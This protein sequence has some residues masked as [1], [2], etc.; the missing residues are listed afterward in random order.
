MKS[1][2]TREWRHSASI[3]VAVALMLGANAMI[4]APGANAQTQAPNSATG[5]KALQLGTI[6][7]T[8]EKRVQPVQEVPM[9]VSVISGAQLERLQAV[10]FSDY[11]ER[12]TGFNYISSGEGQT[13]LILR[14][15]TSG[16]DQANATVGTY[17]D[18]APFGSSTVYAEGSL[19]TPDIDPADIERIE[20]LRGPQGTL[21][22]ANTL[23]GLIKFVTIP[24]NTLQLYGR[25]RIDGTSVQG[26]GS[27]Y[28]FHAM[29]NVPLVSNTLGLRINAYRRIDPGYYNNVA[30]GQNN[31]NKDTVNG[32]R[33]QLLWT[34]NE[35]LSLRLSA[36][37]QNNYNPAGVNGGEDVDPNTLQPIYG[38]LKQNHPPGTGLFEPQYRLYNATV[39]A[40][41]GWAELISS[42]SYDSL[43][44]Q[45]NT[46]VT[47]VYGPL[48]NPL[49]G[50][51]NGGYSVNQPV[52]Q[53]KFTQEIRL[54]SPS[55]DTLEWRAGLFYTHENSNNHQS[56]LTFDATTGQPIALPFTLADAYLGP[57]YFDEYAA[58]G[59]ITYHF[60]PRF[61]LLLG[62]R[63]SHDRTEYTQ[64]TSGV[65]TGTTNFTTS[66]TD[67]PTT[68]LLSPKYK[69][70]KDMMVYARIASGFRPGGANV[71]V[72]PGLNAPIT[73]GPDKLVSYSVG[74]KSTL[75]NK[76]MTFN[77]DGFYVDWKQIQLTTF[78]GGFTYLSNGGTAK[79]EGIEASWNYT[80]VKGLELTANLTYTNAQLT[81]NTPP[82]LIGYS[83]DRLPYVP[84][85]NGYLAADYD[86]SL[87][88]TWYGFAGA[89][90]QFIGSRL[91]DFNSSSGQ[92]LTVPAYR[93]AGVYFGARH[94]RWT[95]EAFI[96]N[97]TNERGITLLSPET[98]TPLA[99]PYS[100]DVIQPRTYGVS[101]SYDFY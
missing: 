46:D 73:F 75:L 70:S 85:W 48:L 61:D 62:A 81:E 24:P 31:V 44:L 16:A 23:G 87:V 28:G 38:D 94:T 30:T 42:T 12:L 7:V 2:Y 72:P 53:G 84:R 91:T 47:S 52:V 9:G 90:Y 64:M 45:Q 25:I 18:E 6:T 93:V 29:L 15:I 65:L 66:G 57:A 49:L 80:P 32:G 76:R 22:G 97:L 8:A 20:V 63:Q 51:T 26:G 17:I 86:F 21:Y 77:V 100:A 43:R 71:G 50:L 99:S 39:N 74:M 79:S 83:G 67:N 41:F 59:D 5:K 95:I 68:F 27:G 34:P 56:V 1:G 14:G 3:F 13:Q 88:P 40:N 96:H 101:L 11:L 10:K 37:A 36:L 55:T 82:G 19:L 4:A 60:T 54:Q 78:N 69:F 89:N 98:I 92:R 33:L 35:S 58:Y